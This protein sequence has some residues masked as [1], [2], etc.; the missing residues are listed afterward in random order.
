MITY[1]KTIDRYCP[2]REHN[3]KVEIARHDD[4]RVTEKCLY[5]TCE[6]EHCRIFR[7]IVVEQRTYRRVPERTER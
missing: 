4:G 2:A 6:K 3:I 7:R 1:K 5:E